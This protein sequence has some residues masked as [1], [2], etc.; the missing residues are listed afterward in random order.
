MTLSENINFSDDGS[1]LSLAINLINKLNLCLFWFGLFFLYF[2]ENK[3]PT[4]DPHVLISIQDR[5]L[6]VQQVPP[7]NKN[8]DTTSISKIWKLTRNGAASRSIVRKYLRLYRYLRCP[9]QRFR[10]EPASSEFCLALAFVILTRHGPGK[11]TPLCRVECAR[12][13]VPT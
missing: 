13:C 4:I 3:K 5:L 9:Q 6:F 8:K 10:E 12:L 1:S 2:Q 7:P 11:S